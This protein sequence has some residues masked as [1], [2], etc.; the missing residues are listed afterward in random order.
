[1]SQKHGIFGVHSICLY[2]LKTGIP[3]A[4]MKIIGECNLQFTAEFTDLMGGSQMFPYDTEISSMKTDISITAREYSPEVSE[5][6]LGGLSTIRAAEVGGAVGEFVNINGTSVLNAT[7]GI[8]SVGIIPSTGAADLKTGRYIIVATDVDD[9]DI[10]ACQDVDNSRG[11]KLILSEAYKVNS[12][13][14]TVSGASTDIAV[15]GI[16]LTKG[17]GTLAFTVGDTAEFWVRKPNESSYDI[18]FGSSGSEFAEF[19][20]Y[21]MGQKSSDGSINMMQI[22]RCK[23]G[24]MPINFKEKGWSEWSGSVKALYNPATDS[25]GRFRRI[26]LAA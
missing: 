9:I 3:F 17:S 26:S 13:P 22:Y 18:E 2:D 15:L 23:A 24:G 14:I 1:M 10:Y 4:L 11:T 5:K 6:F 25:V 16:K 12:A 20:M 8:A 19:G 7:T 21:A